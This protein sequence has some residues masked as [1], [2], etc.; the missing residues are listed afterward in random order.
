MLD[1][2]QVDLLCRKLNLTESGH[3]LVRRIRTSDPA[4]RVGGGRSNVCVRYPSRKMGFV[5]QAESHTVELALVY[6]LEHDPEVLEY[7]DQPEHLTLRYPSKN[8]KNLGISHTPDFLVVRRDRI[9]FV[10]CKTEEDLV[11]L[12]EK[13]PNRY[14]KDEVGRWICPPGEEASSKF[15]LSYRV[16]SSSGIDWIFQDNIRFIED[17]LRNEC[18]DPPPAHSER[19]RS[20]LEHRKAATLSDLL[21]GDHGA[22]ADEI[23]RMIATEQLHFDFRSCRLSE[24]DRAWVALDQGTGKAYALLMEAEKAPDF[25]GALS[26][27]PGEKISWD[28]MAWELVNVGLT[29]IVL[30]SSE[31]KIVSLPVSSFEALVH[32][33]AIVPSRPIPDKGKDFASAV[34]E[35]AGKEALEV[36]NRRCDLLKESPESSSDLAGGNTPSARTLRRWNA[37][38]RAMEQGFGNGY[39]GLLP[40]TPKR[41]NRTSRMNEPVE[42]LMESAIS[43]IYETKKQVRIR[44]AYEQFRLNCEREHLPVPSYETF[45]RAVRNRPKE[46]QAR[47]REGKR[48]AYAH[49][50]FHWRLERTTPRH[51]SRPFEIV[52]VDHTELDIELVGSGDGRTMGRPWLTLMIDA[53]SR[54][55]LAFYL[56]YD[57]PSSQS[58]M[59]IVRDCV[60]RWQRLPAV[61]VL[62]NGKEFDSVYFESLLASYECVKKS[63][64]P[65]QA[66]FGSVCERLF[67]TTNTEMIY[68]LSGNTQITKKVR[69][70]TK[71]FDP[72]RQ[73]I[74][75][76]PDLHAL[77]EEFFF[78]VYNET[79]H[80]A[81]NESPKHV[82]DEGLARTGIR[83]HR[84][85]P[86]SED[87]KMR[88]LPSTPKGTATVN[89]NTGMQIHNIRYWHDGFRNPELSG[90]SVPVRY[91]PENCGIAYAFLS[92]RWVQCI[93][94][95]YETMKGRSLREIAI[96]SRELTAKNREFSKRKK[97]K[98]KDL[99]LFLEGAHRH[100]EI[101]ERRKKDSEAGM[102]VGANLRVLPEKP[103]EGKIDRTE[104]GA[105]FRREETPAR[106]ESVHPSS[107]KNLQVLEDF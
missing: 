64:P 8:G 15:G 9:E 65:A 44:T 60:R 45:R 33:G 21:A 77:L 46:E 87:F 37:S 32:S 4:R 79:P 92:G 88:T 73:A 26:V 14:L 53:Y 57:P 17:Y 2:L 13:M 84:L 104:D 86:Y 68:A 66:R 94:Q 54:S 24:P 105:K 75:T 27:L 40:R 71:S 99:A 62:D 34:L 51:G 25:S 83:S 30:C 107:R 19:V 52:H 56:A 102:T 103:I 63:R 82:L 20:W 93:S 43:E 39:L 31:D 38:F 100:E 90:K 72:K 106:P 74:W 91:D 3:S 61:F 67:G 101:L 5:V 58:C 49:S 69:I 29:S 55:I 6:E 10:E 98:A 96:A 81:L 48:V 78:G 59:M 18:P 28:G 95:Q 1:D 35:S 11:C 70:M 23:Y 97:I 12:S 16:W 47:K 22:N 85:V 80:P 50:I 41:G 76:L 42:R 36:A 89:P 7:Y